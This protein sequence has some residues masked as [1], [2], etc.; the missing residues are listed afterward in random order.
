MDEKVMNK[1]NEILNILIPD[2]YIVIHPATDL[3]VY[4]DPVI[5]D[6]CEMAELKI[7]LSKGERV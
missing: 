2:N 3:R 4:P 5:Q 1:L 7:R 6:L